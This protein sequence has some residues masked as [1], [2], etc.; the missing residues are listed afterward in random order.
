LT[1]AERQKKFRQK[2]QQQKADDAMQRAVAGVMKEHPDDKGRRLTGAPHREGKGVLVSSD[3]K[4]LERIQAW[5]EHNDATLGPPTGFDEKDLVGGRRRVVPEGTSDFR[6]VVVGENGNILQ[7]KAKNFS[8][9]IK[10]NAH[11]YEK[12]INDLVKEHFE[13]CGANFRCR[14]CQA[15]IA[16]HRHCKQHIEDAHSVLV[17]KMAEESAKAEWRLRQQ[18]RKQAK[19]DKEKAALQQRQQ[20]VEEGLTAPGIPGFVTGRK[21]D[22]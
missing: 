3:P 6:D 12:I 10:L 7:P 15:A 20:S 11:Q 9:R 21:S 4:R 2:K 8:W 13:D 22:K 16:W 17:R 14:L 5:L 18:G 19:L 1:G